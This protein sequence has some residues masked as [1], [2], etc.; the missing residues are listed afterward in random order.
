M[1]MAKCWLD[2]SWE[3]SKDKLQTSDCTT[4]KNGMSAC[5]KKKKKSQD[6]NGV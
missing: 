4:I 2:E 1:C 6:G 5:Q 3:S